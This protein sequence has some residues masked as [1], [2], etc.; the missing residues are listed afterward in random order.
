MKTMAFILALY[1]MVFLFTGCDEQ[2]PELKSEIGHFELKV[3]YITTTNPGQFPDEGSK[4]YLFG[5]Q[6]KCPDFYEA[7]QGYA[8]LDGKTITSRYRAR[9]DENGEIYI[10]NMKAG[11]YYMVVISSFH[12]SYTEKIIEVPLGDTL[13]LHKNFS[14]SAKY[15]H[16]LEPWDYVKP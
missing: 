9:A 2:E 13:K 3:T 8:R 11:S 15:W 16:D 14:N 1:Q 12:E 7:M 10:H 5:D 4:M 6:A